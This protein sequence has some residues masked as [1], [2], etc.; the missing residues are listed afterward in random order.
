MPPSAALA[1]LR[2]EAGQ[3][4][5]PSRFLDGIARALRPVAEGVFIGGP[6]P[7]LMERRGGKFRANLLFSAPDR[8]ILARVLDPLPA[9]ITASQLVN[10]VRWHLDVDPHEI[11]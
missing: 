2:A 10:R 6:V 8:K 1:L 5:L 7:A 4:E 3:R 11:G 9:A